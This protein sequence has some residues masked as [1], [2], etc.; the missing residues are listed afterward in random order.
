MLPEQHLDRADILR[1]LCIPDGVNCIP[2]IGFCYFADT[3]DRIALIRLGADIR[4]IQ[5]YTP[6]EALDVA[7]HFEDYMRSKPRM[8]P[9][10]VYDVTFSSRNEF[11]SFVRDIIGQSLLN[12]AAREGMLNEVRLFETSF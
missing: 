10:E 5:P 7:T 1:R 6:D 12:N 4:S 3:P 9:P 2:Y 8:L 11:I